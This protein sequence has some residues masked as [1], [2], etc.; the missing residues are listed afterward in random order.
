M[1]PVKIYH[2][3]LKIDGAKS[4]D[5]LQKLTKRTLENNANKNSY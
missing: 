3:T 4:F 1:K 5:F 2:F